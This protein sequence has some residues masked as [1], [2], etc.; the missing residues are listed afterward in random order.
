M[1]AG[2][3]QVLTNNSATTRALISSAVTCGGM[4][5]Q[6]SGVIDT[7]RVVMRNLTVAHNTASGTS[8]VGGITMNTHGPDATQSQA[9]ARWV[10]G[11]WPPLCFACTVTLLVLRRREHAG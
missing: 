5:L 4:G 1:R 3:W 2:M 6:Q 8:A 11:C 9:L 7:Q 10:D